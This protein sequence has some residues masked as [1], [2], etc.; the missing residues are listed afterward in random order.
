[1]SSDLNK[2]VLHSSAILVRNFTIFFSL[3]AFKKILNKKL[4]YI[5][6]LSH[7]I[8]VVTMDFLTKNNDQSPKSLNFKSISNNNE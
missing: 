6:A 3:N 5:A 2:V 1:R 4:H 8:Q 7:T